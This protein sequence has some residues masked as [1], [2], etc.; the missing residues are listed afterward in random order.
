MTYIYTTLQPAMQGHVAA[1]LTAAG[2]HH[3][4]VSDRG[5]YRVAVYMTEVT[6]AKRIIRAA[7]L[8]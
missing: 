2:I 1:A 6:A 7:G 3:E 5:L 8:Y 4:K